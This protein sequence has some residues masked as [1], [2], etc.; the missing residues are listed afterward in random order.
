[1]KTI[2]R[3][4]GIVHQL[5][6]NHGIHLAVADVI[7]CVKYCDDDGDFDEY[8][9]NEAD[10]KNEFN[11]EVGD[12]VKKVRK[13]VAFFQRSTVINDC[14]QKMCEDMLGKNLALI[15]DSRVR[16][17]SMLAMLR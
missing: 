10:I 13:I 15:M 1:M 9:E 2:G 14:L 4:L 16:W 17:K 7:Y 12:V 6:Y 8:P 3:L 11:V 5:C